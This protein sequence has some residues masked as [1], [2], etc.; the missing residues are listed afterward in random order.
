MCRSVHALL[1]A[2]KS[3]A[4]FSIAFPFHV[5]DCEQTS[6]WH[7]SSSKALGV[8]TQLLVALIRSAPK[9]EIVISR[10]AFDPRAARSLIKRIKELPSVFELNLLRID[11][12]SIESSS[13]LADYFR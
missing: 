5:Q 13:T 7:L 12:V 6:K 2:P 9:V 10:C 8:A 1:E 3:E 11:D 4:K